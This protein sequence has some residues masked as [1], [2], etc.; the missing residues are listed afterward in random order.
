MSERVTCNN[1]LKENEDGYTVTQ[2]YP[3]KSSKSFGKPYQEK[4]I[5]LTVKHDQ[6]IIISAH[7]FQDHEKTAVF[8]NLQPSNIVTLIDPKLQQ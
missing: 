2:K 8:V 1:K 5:V 6:I 7:F 4:K 3:S